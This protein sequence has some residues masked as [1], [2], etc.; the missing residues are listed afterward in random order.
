MCLLTAKRRC[1]V[2]LVASL[3][4]VAS[5]SSSSTMSGW[6]HFSC[7]TIWLW[8]MYDIVKQ[9]LFLWQSTC[10]ILLRRIHC[11]SSWLLIT[12][13]SSYI[14]L[15]VVC[16]WFSSE[17]VSIWLKVNFLKKCGIY[18]SQP[19][20]MLLFAHITF[21]GIFVIHCQ[22]VKTEPVSQGNSSELS[23]Q[24]LLKREINRTQ[25]F[26]VFHRYVINWIYYESWQ[27]SIIIVLVYSS[28]THSLC[29]I[30]GDIFYFSS[31]G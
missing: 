11:E 27:Q 12:S 31:L 24:M 13:Y 2:A 17:T 16:I 8:E 29:S 30:F 5:S 4:L 3:L 21:A 9:L 6:L 20:N 14:K 18:H 10:A 28:S 22:R 26:S 25:H 15:M 7:L 23:L 1:G 19:S